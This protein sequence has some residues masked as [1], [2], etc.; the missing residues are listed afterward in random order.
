MSSLQRSVRKGLRRFGV[1]VVRFP[2]HS[3]LEGHLRALLVS[4]QI[5]VVL[6]VGAHIGEFAVNWRWNVDR[7][8]RGQCWKRSPRNRCR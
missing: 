3:T 1:D 2:I 4:Y 8:I 5:S 6:D 7:P